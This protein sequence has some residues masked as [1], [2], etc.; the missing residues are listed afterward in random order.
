[1]WDSERT[2]SGGVKPDDILRTENGIQFIAFM[3]LFI[4]RRNI[5]VEVIGISV[6]AKYR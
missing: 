6:L 4:L 3:S 2:R 5:K 1:M